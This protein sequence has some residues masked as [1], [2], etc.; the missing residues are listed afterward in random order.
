MGKYNEFN[1][2]EDEENYEEI[3][4]YY[5]C[6]TCPEDLKRAWFDQKN[7][8]IFWICSEGHRSEIQVGV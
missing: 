1:K 4:G 7:G 2:E 3:L 5:G 6:Q 8:T